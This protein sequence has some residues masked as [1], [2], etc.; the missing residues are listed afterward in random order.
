MCDLRITCVGSGINWQGVALSSGSSWVG[1]LLFVTFC[2]SLQH[3]LSLLSHLFLHQSS[4]NGFQC[5]TFPKC[6]MPQSQQFSVNSSATTTLFRRLVLDLVLVHHSRMR[7]HHKLNWRELNQ[8]NW[9]ILKDKVT[10]RPTVSGPVCLGVRHPRAKKSFFFLTL[11]SESW[12]SIDMN[13]FS[14]EKTGLE[15]AVAT[16][17]AFLGSEFCGTC[18][19]ILLSQIWVFLKLEGMF[20]FISSRNRVVQLH[21]RHWI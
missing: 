3:A 17:A 18:D 5:R 16:V 10:L 13:N 15:F 7:S 1:I 9:T 12:R 8:V 20:L 11:S 19:Q 14:N 4:G 2:N 21:P 6:S